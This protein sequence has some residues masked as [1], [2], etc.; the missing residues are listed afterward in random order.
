MPP[1]TAPDTSASSATSLEVDASPPP[2]S[3][4][5]GATAQDLAG[6]ATATDWTP[7]IIV[8]VI[9][10]PAIFVLAM[11]FCHRRRRKRPSPPRNAEPQINVQ[12]AGLQH[13]AQRARPD[14]P[15]KAV[16]IN[17]TRPCAR[18]G[19]PDRVRARADDN[20]PITMAEILQTPDIESPGPNLSNG[21]SNRPLTYGA[22]P[23][24]KLPQPSVQAVPAKK[25][26]DVQY[27]LSGGERGD[28]RSENSDS[29]LKQ[30][31]ARLPA[32]PGA[33]APSPLGS[34]GPEIESHTCRH[35]GREFGTANGCATHEKTCMSCSNGNKAETAP[36]G[37]DREFRM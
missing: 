1:P 15:P 10:V 26:Y 6:S 32:Q 5:D 9:L 33:T 8:L 24:S 34:P 27:S 7:L 25:A 31:L 30:R 16:T 2:A 35:C 4:V 17:P 11:R 37:G 13:N 20:E 18:R 19:A 36:T 29:L 3:G 28:N 12:R 21:R 22:A 14:G 23:Q